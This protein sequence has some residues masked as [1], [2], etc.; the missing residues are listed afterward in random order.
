MNKKFLTELGLQATNAGTSTGR[1]STDSGAYI[2]SYSP[3]DGALIGKVS[4]TTRAEYEA[5]VER[6]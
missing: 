2:E 3:V 4:T 5:V 6:M 1:H